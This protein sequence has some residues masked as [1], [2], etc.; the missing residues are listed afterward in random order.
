MENLMLTLE[1]YKSV[2]GVTGVLYCHDDILLNLTNLPLGKAPD[3]VITSF[4]ASNPRIGLD[5]PRRREEISKVS[6][7]LHPDGSSSKVDGFNSSNPH[8]LLASLSY[9]C[10]FEGCITSFYGVLGDPRAMKYREDQD[11]SLLVPPP[12]PA[13]A[14]FLYV[15]TSLADAYQEAAQIMVDHKVF[16]E[17]GFPKIVDI[18]QQRANATIH[19]VSLCTHTSNEQERGSFEMIGACDGDHPIGLV[20]PF[21]LG[22]AGYQNWTR[23]FDWMVAGDESRKG[24]LP[25]GA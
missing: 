18:L 9:W 21:K 17:C 13:A 15:S 5:D 24:T 2:D 16:L 1:Q 4:D 11:Q 14:D 19:K 6:Y 12:F 7:R 3:S 25:P 20:H 23:A 10:W 8:D 22:H